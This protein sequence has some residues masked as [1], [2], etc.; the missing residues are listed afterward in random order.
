MDPL[1][2]VVLSVLQNGGVVGT[3]KSVQTLT[4][5]GT[6]STS[7]GWIVGTANT[8]DARYLDITINSVTVSKSFCIIQDASSDPTKV[9]ARVLNSST[10]RLSAFNDVTGT[11]RILINVI[12]FY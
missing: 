4:Y 5:I 11:A 9:T 6:P 1:S 10:I 7:N 3:Y 12:E 2:P 8:F